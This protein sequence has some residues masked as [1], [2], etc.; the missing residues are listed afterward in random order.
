MPDEPA[1]LFDADDAVA[2]H[3]TEPARFAERH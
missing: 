1:V 2:T 3:N